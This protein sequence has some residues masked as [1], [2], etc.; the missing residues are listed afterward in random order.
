MKKLI[1]LMVPVATILL[2]VG[3]GNA[4][5][6]KNVKF[7]DIMN[8]DKKVSLILSSTGEGSKPSKDDAVDTF[9]V[10]ENGKVTSYTSKASYYLEDL[11]GKSEEEIINIAKKQDKEYFKQE[12]ASSLDSLKLDLS[13]AKEGDDVD[14]EEV[15]EKEKSIKEIE[16]TK[17]TKP[18]PRKLEI[19][20]TTDGSGNKTKREEFYIQ[21]REFT[22]TKYESSPKSPIKYENNKDIK[23][24]SVA[25]DSGAPTTKI[26]N[27]NYAYLKNSEESDENTKYYLI[28]KV[29]DKTEKSELDQPDSKY[30]KE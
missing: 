5:N 17:Y 4:S 6:K 9:V 16:N 26:Y 20:V 3:C 2:L 10:T 1:L 18:S 8:G 23:D 28:T 12:K 29:G 7:G 21:G 13:F 15:E 14:K 22:D 25:V 24:K 19:A 11:K 30:V 27:N